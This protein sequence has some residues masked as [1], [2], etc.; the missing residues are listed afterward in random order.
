MAKIK[1]NRENFDNTVAQG[2]VLVDFFATWCAPCR[3]LMPIV[4]EIANERSDIKVG[5]VNVDE[6]RELA[7]RFRISS[8]PTL[9]ILRDGEMVSRTQGARPKAALLE[10][11]DEAL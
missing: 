9:L 7:E 2:V 3:A 11:L 10:L 8:I 1:L 4:E 5:C 6:E